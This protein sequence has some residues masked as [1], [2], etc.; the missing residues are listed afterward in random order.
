MSITAGYL[1]ELRIVSRPKPAVRRLTPSPAPASATPAISGSAYGPARSSRVTWSTVDSGFHVASRTGEF[2][3]SIDAT[4]DGHFIAFDGTNAPIGRYSAMKDAQD[5]VAGWIPE[6]TRERER[7]LARRF[8]P[9]A[10][11]AAVVAVA[12]ALIGALS[13][14]LPA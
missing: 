3:G 6:R 14:A 9:V 11:S 1:P 8:R 5:A 4:E 2:V 13:T 10:T 12:T 7:T